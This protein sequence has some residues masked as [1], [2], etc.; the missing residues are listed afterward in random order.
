ME[1]Y[2]RES[3]SSRCV[4]PKRAPRPA[5]ESRLPL[6]PRPWQYSLSD[7]TSPRR[8]CTNGGN[9]KA[10]PGGGGNGSGVALSGMTLTATKPVDGP[11]GAGIT[12][13]RSSTR[14]AYRVFGLNQ[15]G[16]PRPRPDGVTGYARLSENLFNRLFVPKVQTPY[17]G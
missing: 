5:K 7:T 12:A 13:L 16:V 6:M 8:L 4:S 11:C 9:V 3:T 15:L 14:H 17:L 2:G 1:P 10:C